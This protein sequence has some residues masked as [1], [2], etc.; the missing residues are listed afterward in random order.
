MRIAFFLAESREELPGGCSCLLQECYGHIC[1]FPEN[2]AKTVI[3]S[4]LRVVFSVAS[5]SDSFSD[6]FCAANIVKCVVV[7]V[8][9]FRV[10]TLPGEILSFCLELFATICSS[11]ECIACACF[12]S[13]YEAPGKVC[14]CNL[15][16]RHFHLPGRPLCLFCTISGRSL[17]FRLRE[18][19]L[20]CWQPFSSNK[21][22]QPNH[23]LV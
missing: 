22:K 21:N 23:F 11:S 17:G 7:H 13:R 12:A 10:F 18:S 15:F 5:L 19:G 14:G 9:E 6:N 4:K 16:K 1:R 2:K 8:A 20:P 3:I